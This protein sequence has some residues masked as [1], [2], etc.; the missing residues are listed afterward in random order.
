MNYN[1]NMNSSDDDSNSDDDGMGQTV[2]QI[3]QKAKTETIRLGT[4]LKVQIYDKAGPVML[5]ELNEKM[6]EME[7][8]IRKE[9]EEK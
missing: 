1:N 8:K 2:K 3:V 9:Q 4:I 6:K 5:V 7:E